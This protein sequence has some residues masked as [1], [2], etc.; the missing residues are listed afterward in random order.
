MI[1]CRWPRYLVLW[2]ISFLTTGCTRILPC[3]CIKCQ[4]GGKSYLGYSFQN[5]LKQVFMQ[6]GITPLHSNAN[7]TWASK[8][9][10]K[11]VLVNYIIWD[12]TPFNPLKDT[13]LHIGF[14]LGLHLNSEEGDMVSLTRRFFFQ[15]TPR[16]YNTEDRTL[17]NQICENFKSHKHKQRFQ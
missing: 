10:Y 2:N 4:H 1:R 7:F 16:C 8:H 12:T 17:H 5:K 6:V 15:Q 11:Q 14:L 3:V 9:S 13:L